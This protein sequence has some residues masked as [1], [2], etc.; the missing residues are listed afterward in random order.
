MIVS[1]AIL[2]LL[3]SAALAHFFYQNEGR[4]IERCYYK[5]NKFLYS[6]LMFCTFVL[7]VAAVMNCR[8]VVIVIGKAVI[9]KYFPS[10]DLSY[11]SGKKA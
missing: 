3:S 11:L 5:E 7:I 9:A 1:C 10:L 6:A 2:A 8:Q 4:K